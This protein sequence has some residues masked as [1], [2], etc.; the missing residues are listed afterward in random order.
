VGGMTV[1]LRDI[2]S[3]G[4]ARVDLESGSDSIV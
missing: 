4:G 3:M 2:M 1:L